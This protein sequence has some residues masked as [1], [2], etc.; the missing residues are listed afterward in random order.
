MHTLPQLI[1]EDL[2]QLDSILQDFLD[3]TDAAAAL[4]I[5]QGGFLITH[6]GK[7]RQ[8]DLTTI[9]ALASGA[10]LATQTIAGLVHET[11]FNAVYQAG[12]KNSIFVL[13]IDEYCMLVVIFRT[14]VTAGVVK[15][16]AVPATKA[17]AEQLRAAQARDPEGGFDLSRINI[18]NPGQLFRAKK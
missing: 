7:T 12:E 18:A 14:T 11:T 5:D 15:H 4:V 17:I 13:N 16:F 2:Q 3:K 10:Y 9:A 1:E 8:F 6:Q